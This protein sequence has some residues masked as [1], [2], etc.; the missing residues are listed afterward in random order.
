MATW[1]KTIQCMEKKTLKRM[2]QNKTNPFPPNNKKQ[3]KLNLRNLGPNNSMSWSSFR[4]LNGV[5]DL[6]NWD[7]FSLIEIVP[8][9][10]VRLITCLSPHQWAD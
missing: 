3:A 5:K 10:V 2:H 7:K 6:F 4:F 1:I 9:R 8:V